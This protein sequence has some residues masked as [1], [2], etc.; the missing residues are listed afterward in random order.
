MLVFLGKVLLP[1]DF[2]PKRRFLLK[3]GSTQTRNNRIKRQLEID[4]N[5]KQC[6]STQTAAKNVE[7]NP[8][9]TKSEKQI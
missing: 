9:Q 6:F 3:F 4:P 7:I 5:P 1:I 2:L 8:T